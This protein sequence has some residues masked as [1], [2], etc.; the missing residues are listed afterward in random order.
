MSQDMEKDIFAEQQY[1]QLA[2]KKLAPVSDNFRLISAGWLG[3]KPE[4]WEVMKVTGAEFRVAKAGPH[5]GKL[6]I[7][8]KGTQRSAHVTRKD[9]V[10]ATAR[11]KKHTKGADL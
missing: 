11:A 5:K 3:Q 2:L 6:S 7:M 1:G 10:A 8:V 4:D 9:I